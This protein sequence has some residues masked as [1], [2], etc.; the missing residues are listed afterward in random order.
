MYHLSIPWKKVIHDHITVLGKHLMIMKRTGSSLYS[1]RVFDSYCLSSLK[2]DFHE[3]GSQVSCQ[4]KSTK[5]NLLSSIQVESPNT[6]KSKFLLGPLHSVGSFKLCAFHS[7]YVKPQHRIQPVREYC[8]A[9][10]ITN[11]KLSQLCSN[12]SPSYDVKH[13]LENEDLIVNQLKQRKI[14]ISEFDFTQMREKYKEFV[15]VEKITTELEHKLV[16]LEQYLLVNKSKLQPSQLEKKYLERKQL[17]A[18]IK[19]FDSFMLDYQRNVIIKVLKLPNYLDSS[20]PEVYET[21]Y[22]DDPDREG[23][24]KI[25]MDALSKYVQYTNRL[26]I[27]YLGNAAKFEY[28]IPIILKDYF[29]VKHNFMPFTNT[30]LCKGVIVEGYGDHY[31]SPHDNMVLVNNENDLS[32]IGYEERRNHLVGSA[33]MSMFCA[34]HTNHS[35]NVKDLPVKYVTSGKQYGFHNLLC[36]NTLKTSKHS[37][38]ENLYNSIQREKVNLF[39]GTNNHENLCKEFQNIQSL[40]KSIMDKLNMKYRI[41]KAP[42]DVLHTSESHR[43]EYQ[44]YSYSLNSWVTCMDVCLNN[45]YVSKRLSMCYHRSVT[46]YEKQY[47]HILNA[48]VFVNTLLVNYLENNRDLDVEQFRKSLNTEP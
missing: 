8:S 9:L 19:K 23:K 34:Y 11:D 4:Q 17:K 44:V 46:S 40:L 12:V 32:E 28:L 16:D 18:E 25:D 5:Q 20:T 24:N 2:R 38:V 30:D 7:K 31:L 1:R 22:E 45:D 15:G 37:R 29:T 39:V 10:F 3:R 43:I 14:D 47:L 26:D 35:V 13:V 41:C 6:L 42:A 36:E 21:I 27:H 48:N 33:H